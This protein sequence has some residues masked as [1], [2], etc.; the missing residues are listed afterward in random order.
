MANGEVLGSGHDPPTKTKS[1][2]AVGIGPIG[3]MHDCVAMSPKVRGRLEE[4]ATERDEATVG[5]PLGGKVILAVS[6]RFV[7]GR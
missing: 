7:K 1:P 5:E 2:N 6:K 3:N 4:I